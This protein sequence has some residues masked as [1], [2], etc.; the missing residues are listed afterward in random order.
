MLGVGCGMWDVGC[1][2]LHVRKT[3]EREESSHSGQ[4]LS[5][6]Y[7]VDSTLQR[8]AM[9]NVEDRM[10]QCPNVLF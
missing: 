5:H 6:Q 9:L 4:L 3:E 7:T 2:M 1:G 8:S 10:F